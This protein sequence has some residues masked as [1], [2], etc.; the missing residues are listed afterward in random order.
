MT[1]VLTLL[2]WAGLVRADELTCRWDP[3]L[4]ATICKSQGQRVPTCKPDTG[5][6]RPSAGAVQPIANYVAGLATP[7][8]C[9]P[10]LGPVRVSASGIGRAVGGEGNPV[11]WRSLERPEGVCPVWGAVLDQQRVR[12]ETAIGGASALS[13]P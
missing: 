9:R 8:P 3:W 12:L 11:L 6:A 4:R 10:G 13:E 5:T 7:G 1:A 2:S